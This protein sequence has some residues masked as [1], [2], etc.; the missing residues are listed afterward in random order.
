V[1]GIVLASAADERYGYHLV[2]MIGSVQRNS[3]VFDAIVV[4]DLGLT[5]HQLGLLRPI[6][7]VE[8]RRVPPFAPHW[9]QG[10]TW[11][12]WIWT[13]LDAERIFYLDAGSTVLRRLDDVLGAIDRLGYFVV[14]QG[15]P[16]S[17]L[18]PPDYFDL[19]GLDRAAAE[20]T[21]V[22]AGIIGF[23]TRGRFWEQVV[24]PTYEDCL[25][26]RSLG[27][28]PHEL[29]RLNFGIGRMDDPPVRDAQLFRWDQSVLNAHFLR[30][31]PEAEIADVFRFAGWRS[32]REHPRQVIWNHRRAC[33][34]AYVGRARY[35][36]QEALRARLFGAYLRY[37]V[38]WLRNARFFM[39]SE[40]RRKARSLLPAARRT[41]PPA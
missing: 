40:Y 18:L 17:S 33:D 22:A 27:F 30:Q 20:R 15:F 13:H 24:V 23:E 32:P 14:G 37:R 35:P 38:W 1:S 8:V 4:H 26:G 2:N 19:Y 12:P 39:A 34:Y 21:S 36:L 10:F 7:G 25:A 29:E 41:Q 28:S 3:D 5:E 16:V 31:Y 11:K 9:S 6:R